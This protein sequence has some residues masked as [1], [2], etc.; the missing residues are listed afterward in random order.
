MDMVYTAEKV[1][2]TY[3]K[4]GVWQVFPKDINEKMEKAYGRNKH[5]SMILEVDGYT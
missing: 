5:G 4:D 1:S 2:W 3:Q